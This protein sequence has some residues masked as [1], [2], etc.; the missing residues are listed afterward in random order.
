MNNEA[1]RDAAREGHF[2]IIKYLVEKC[3]CDPFDSRGGW[4]KIKDRNA[5]QLA[6]ENNHKNIVKYL[7]SL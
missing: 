2:E 1:I 4:K 3:K 6:K 5:L 7:N